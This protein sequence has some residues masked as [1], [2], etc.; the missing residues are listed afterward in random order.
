MAGRLRAEPTR[1]G[2]AGA[3]ADARAGDAGDDR[4]GAAAP[5]PCRAGR[6]PSSARRYT[7]AR[8]ALVTDPGSWRIPP[9]PFADV[10][11]LAAELGVSEVLAQVLVR[12]GL[13]DPA[14]ARAFLHPD[15]R[16]HD[17]YLMTRHGRGAAAHRP[18]AA[19][20]RAHRRARRLRRRRHHRDVPPGRACSRSSAPTCAGACPTASARATG[21]RRRRSTSSPPPASS[22]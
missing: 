14:A 8:D 16:V 1:R 5:E 21:S 18:G 9:A 15:F 4:S 7:G 13:G 12:R 22:C 2:A 10:R 6:H 17:P 19:P 3:G 20:R 11:R